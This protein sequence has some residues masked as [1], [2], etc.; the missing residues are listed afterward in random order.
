MSLPGNIKPLY[1]SYLAS[2]ILTIWLIALMGWLLWRNAKK[3]PLTWLVLPVITGL[4]LWIMHSLLMNFSYKALTAEWLF[5]LAYLVGRLIEQYSLRRPGA[6]KV[7][8]VLGLPLA[9]FALWNLFVGV[10]NSHRGITKV[11]FKLIEVIYSL[12]VVSWESF[13]GFYFL[14]VKPGIFFLRLLPTNS[15]FF[16]KLVIALFGLK[17][18]SVL[19]S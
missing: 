7:A 9:A 12:L 14:R 3:L 16:K 15:C 5:V 1:S 10:E 17:N 4:V 18:N 13:F 19:V 6:G 11:S 8:L 2:V